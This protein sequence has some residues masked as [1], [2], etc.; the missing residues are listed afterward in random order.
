MKTNLP[1]TNRE[2]FM[3]DGTTIVTKTD[4]KGI[5]KFANPEFI[6]ISGFSE[7]ELLEQSHNIVRHPDMPPSAFADL[8]ATL[9]QGKPWT[10]MVKNRCKNGDH[11]WVHAHV[12][13][14]EANGQLVGYTS[15]RTKPSRADVDEAIKLYA[16]LKAGK[17][18]LREGVAQPDGILAKLNL[19]LIVSR[20]SVNAQI[21][22]M[23][24]AF[25]LVSLLTGLLVYSTMTQVQVN[26]PIY[27]RVVQGK[28]LVADILP[29]PEYLLESYLVSLQMLNADGAELQ[30]LAASSKQLRAD[31]EDRHQF[32][33]KELPEGN[34][35]TL[36]VIDA[37]EAGNQFLE[38]RDQRFIPA[39]LAGNRHAA[40]EVLEPMKK[41]YAEHRALIDKV[42]VLANERNS[43]DEKDAAAVIAKK[44]FMLMVLA[45]AGMIVVV[46][47][48]VMVAR[49]V[50]RLLGG[51]PRYARE[52]TKHV[53]SGNLAVRVN[54]DP[55][56][57]TSLLA[58]IKYMQEMFRK[59]VKETQDNAN[60][61]AQVAQQMAAASEQVS[62]TAMQSSSS[63][64]TMASATEQMTQSMGTVVDQA[65]E[66]HGISAQS[67]QTCQDG[68]TVIQQ[69]VQSMEKIASTVRESTDVVQTLGVQSEQI[70]SVVK[71]I[72]EIAD[73][74]NLLALNAAIEAAR[75]GEQGRG[76]AV[77]ADE[78]RKLAERTT[79]STE[80]IAKMI[81]AIQQGM[82][83]VVSG[84]E[85]GVQQVDEG[86]GEANQAGTAIQ[87]IRDGAQRVLQVVAD[88]AGSLGEQ[89]KASEQIAQQVEEI[90]RMAEENSAVSQEASTGARQLLAAATKMQ[91]TANRFAV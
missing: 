7:A 30:A 57:H 67:E 91:G 75:A 29:P 40:E 87:H 85:R 55:G 69:A 62:V 60:Q 45:L 9:K 24:G 37:Y 88:I 90:A 81:G 17:V 71:T 18:C 77:V 22:L 86:V 1:V 13:P 56:D 58:T 5:I 31:F 63:A 64:E 14:M 32:W 11:Y 28:D 38:L 36:M 15:I 54:I 34:L 6:Q 16:N 35:K 68:V 78:V 20:L 65:K 84:M 12:S 19:L 10:G 41:K 76:F 25:M 43:A 26:G 80:E 70:S 21:A 53:A 51:D 3:D 23:L 48:S 66:A 89:G 33:V 49:N 82:S 39:L 59:V 2:V 74:T 4:L 73:Q 46:A 8:W 72:R 61:V 79:N 52:I 83:D 44:S 42:V 47:L 27:K 50:R